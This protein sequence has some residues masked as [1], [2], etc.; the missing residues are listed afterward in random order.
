MGFLHSKRAYPRLKPLTSMC[1][2]VCVCVCVYVYVC[3]CVCVRVWVC[4]CLAWCLPLQVQHTHSHTH[5][6]T[7]T[8]TSHTELQTHMHIGTQTHTH[9]HMRSSMCT[10]KHTLIFNQLESRIK[11]LRL[12]FWFAFKRKFYATG[13]WKCVWFFWVAFKCKFYATGPYSHRRM[14]V[15]TIQTDIV[16]CSMHNVCAQLAWIHACTQ[17]HTH[18]K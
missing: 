3:V 17:G 8:N 6:H 2:C 18:L 7:H 4:L 12:I 9:K 11:D 16:Q 1:V 10:T 14:H 13:P 5:T 15:Y